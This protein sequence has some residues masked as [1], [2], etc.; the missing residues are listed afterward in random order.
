MPLGGALDGGGAE[1]LMHRG[2]NGRWV[3]TLSEEDNRA[4]EAKVIEKLGEGCAG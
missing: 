2:V 4:Y 3:D 1:T